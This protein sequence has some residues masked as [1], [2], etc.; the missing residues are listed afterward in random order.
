MIRYELQSTLWILGR[1]ED[2]H[3]IPRS[4][5]TTACLNR[6]HVVMANQPYCPELI[7][8]NPYNACKV[9]KP[10]S[11]GSDAG[12]RIATLNMNNTDDDTHDGRQMHIRI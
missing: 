1:I 12:F 7:W 11:S 6:V 8:R 2:A 3:G 10:G 5:A 4:D 9:G